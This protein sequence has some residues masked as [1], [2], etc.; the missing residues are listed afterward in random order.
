LAESVQKVPGESTPSPLI[1]KPGRYDFPD[2]SD[3]V[4]FL[5]LTSNLAFSKFFNLF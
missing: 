5:I 1:G 3:A 4:I 2:F